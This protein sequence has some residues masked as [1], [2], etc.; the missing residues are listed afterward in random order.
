MVNILETKISAAGGKEGCVERFVQRRL[1]SL[2]YYE[3]G[4]R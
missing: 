4:C 2:L 3:D 1:F